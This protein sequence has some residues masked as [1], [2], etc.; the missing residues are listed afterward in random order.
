MTTNFLNTSTVFPTGQTVNKTLVSG[1]NGQLLQVD[2]TNPT[3]FSFTTANAA[4]IAAD[5][6]ITMPAVTYVG[7]VGL[8]SIGVPAGGF[9]LYFSVGG[10]TGPA[11]ETFYNAIVI[12]GVLSASPAD[13]F[14][15][16]VPVVTSKAIVN[17]FGLFYYID[18]TVGGSG[19]ADANVTNPTQSEYDTIRSPLTSSLNVGSQSI[20]SSTGNVTI[21]PSS[22]VIDVT[23]SRITNVATPTAL[24]D[25]TNLAYVSSVALPFANNLVATASSVLGGEVYVNVFSGSWSI[26]FTSVQANYL[27]FYNAAAIGAQI[28]GN[29]TT[30]TSPPASF[31]T[32]N[33]GTVNFKQ[34]VNFSGT[35]LYRV[36]GAAGTATTGYLTNITILPY[37]DVRVPLLSPIDVG[38]Q[39]LIS[40]SGSVIIDPANNLIDVTSS[41]I[42]NL[43]EPIAVTD[44]ATLQTVNN[45]AFPGAQNLISLPAATTAGPLTLTIPLA[46]NWSMLVPQAFY[47]A[48]V[49]GG[50]ITADPGTGTFG[51]TNNFV[52]TLIND[53]GAGTYTIAGTYTGPAVQGTVTNIRQQQY[54]TIRTP[55]VSA[56][57]VGNQNII[58][59]TGD[60]TINPGSDL[61]NVTNSRIINCLNPTIAQDVSTKAYTDAGDAA[62]LAAAIS[63][64]G[65]GIRSFNNATARNF[66]IP[67]PAEASWT[68][69]RVPRVLQFYDGATWNEFAQQSG[70]PGNLNIVATPSGGVTFNQYYF[71]A[72]GAAVGAAVARGTTVLAIIAAAAGGGGSFYMAYSG[73]NPPNPDYR[74]IPVEYLIVAG[75]GG[76]GGTNAEFQAGGAGGGAGGVLQGISTVQISTSGLQV[77]YPVTVGIGGVAGTNQTNITAK[78]GY[79]TN[80]ILTLGTNTVTGNGNITLTAAGGGFGGT[81]TLFQS[82]GASGGSGGGG[83]DGSPGGNATPAGQGNPGAQNTS[84][85]GSGGGGGAGAPGNNATGGDGIL[86][87]IANTY[88]G[89]YYG[90]GGGARFGAGGAGGGGF[91]GLGV[92]NPAQS[93][94]NG[95]GGG[96]GGAEFTSGGFGG[97]GGTGIILVRYASRTI[98]VIPG[99]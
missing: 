63:T 34:I 83:A 23:N 35:N 13:C 26:Q 95:T 78:G 42:V 3:G 7:S 51:S 60:V 89:N 72:N 87:Y 58:S 69:L 68:F 29:Q 48:V 55:L 20:I 74:T 80:T 49:V 18:G 9:R 97:A 79:G 4:H 31:G 17:V 8:T 94:T 6:L 56:L 24:T 61:I 32:N 57:D 77:N 28:T 37:A 45:L 76:G 84:F 96:G 1:Q 40:S 36:F 25:A 98:P 41:R 46:G 54:T 62:T 81:R 65:N 75:G 52:T 19:F 86:N 14:G 27:A 21:N 38:S 92:G 50:R 91:G 85:F 22:D 88:Y 16:G 15:T 2:S 99:S 33:I 66:A 43:Q 59:S 64:I 39:S 53:P 93:G 10:A 5:N 47:D 90:G 82:V 70:L 30:P 73:V 44:A 11:K 71:D 12:G 67:V